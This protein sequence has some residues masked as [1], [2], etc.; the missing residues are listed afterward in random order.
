MT[1]AGEVDLARTFRPETVVIEPRLYEGLSGLPVELH[2]C[3]PQVR[4]I[5]TQ[6][7]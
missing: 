4:Q 2:R 3:D 1:P 6:G 7:R 5:A